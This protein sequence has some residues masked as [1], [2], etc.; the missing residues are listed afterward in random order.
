[1]RYVDEITFGAMIVL[2]VAVAFLMVL[3]IGAEACCGLSALG[4]A[5]QHPK[6]Q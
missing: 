1:M 3:A 4:L 2:V 6:R 5:V